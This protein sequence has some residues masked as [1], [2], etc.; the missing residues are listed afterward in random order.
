MILSTPVFRYSNIQIVACCSCPMPPG[1]ARPPLAAPQANAGR[2]WL[3]GKLAMASG[4]KRTKFQNDI[5]EK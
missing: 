4:S 2:P 5:Y 1:L 3:A